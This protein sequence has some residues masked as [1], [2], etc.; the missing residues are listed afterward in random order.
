MADDPGGRAS[1]DKEQ[2]SAVLIPTT[3]SA[4]VSTENTP[5]SREQSAVSGVK[6]ST[7]DIKPELRVSPHASGKVD[8]FCLPVSCLYPEDGHIRPAIGPGHE[9]PADK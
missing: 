3:Q 9:P 8:C 4:A 6:T 1:A 7:A 5:I 2:S